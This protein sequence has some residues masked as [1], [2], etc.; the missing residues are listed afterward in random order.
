MLL[1]SWLRTAALPGPAPWVAVEREQDPARF[2]HA[3]LEALRR[4]GAIAADDPLATLAP[5]PGD[6]R[7]TSSSATCSTASGNWRSPSC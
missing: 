2:W 5:A 6:A 7:G 1:A 3:V 4:S